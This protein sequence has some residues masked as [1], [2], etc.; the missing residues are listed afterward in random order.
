[1]TVMVDK[2]VA[3][4]ERHPAGILVIDS[5]VQRSLIDARVKKMAAALNTD[6]IGVI[7]VSRRA[8]GSLIVLDGQHR[9]A[10]LIRNDMS[11]FE[12]DCRMYHGLSLAEEADLFRVLN[13]SA[14]LSA[15]DDF[16]KGVLAGDPECVAIDEI[17]TSKGLRIEKTP[18]ADCVRAIDKLRRIYRGAGAGAPQPHVLSTTLDVAIAAWGVTTATTEGYVLYGLGVV[19]ERYYGEEQLDAGVLVRKLAKLPAGP[20]GLLNDARQMSKLRQGG[21]GK[22]AATLV[23][24]VY[25]SGRR[26]GALPDW[27]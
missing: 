18:Q 8:D 11:D 27:S 14:K 25:N 13:D 15:M 23:V 2:F 3:T 26:T 1:M 17:V 16:K 12:V 22:W 4:F 5:R 20:L 6:G 21:V 9:I 24:E 10:A 19:L 7:H